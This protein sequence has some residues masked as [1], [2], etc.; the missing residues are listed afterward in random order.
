[1]MI[2]T[3]EIS[4]F[5]TQHP[6]F[7]WALLL[8]VITLLV[9]VGVRVLVW[10]WWQRHYFHWGS[11]AQTL[12]L[13]PLRRIVL[14]FL[15]LVL[16][17]VIAFVLR[18]SGVLIVGLMI[19]LV[20]LY[21]GL[22]LS[23]I[24]KEDKKLHT[25]LP[26]LLRSL[27]STLKAGYSVPQALVFV[28]EQSQKPMKSKLKSGVRLLALQ[29]PLEMALREWQQQLKSAEFNFLADS[30]R[31]QSRSGG[32]LV[33]LCHSVASLLEER[34]KLEQ[35]IKSFT[36]QGKMSGVLMAALWPISLLLFAWL[37][38][39]H[40]DVLFSSTPGRILL[41][42]SL[43]LELIGFFLIWRLVRLKI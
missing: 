38:P 23:R 41:G 3:K 19:G 25:Q 15:A 28:A 4:S 26:M 10:C 7:T 22:K 31:L 30:L 29:Q 1:M 40:T 33:E 20:V 32:D 39:S 16:V 24:K 6:T 18:L 8:T 2:F 34:H 42:L 12:S 5:L 43:Y 13:Q 37:S 17:F 27:G 35:D 14:I 21:L 11:K 36:A 9:L